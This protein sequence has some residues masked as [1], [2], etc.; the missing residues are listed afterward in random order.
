MANIKI[1]VDSSANLSELAG[2]AFYSAPLKIITSIKEYIDD[3]R[4]DVSQMVSD[5]LENKER[6]STSCPNVGDWLTAF[7]DDEQILCVTI[8]GALSG[9]YNS[10]VLAKQTYETQHPERSVFV[11]DSLSTG[12]EMVLLVEKARDLAIQGMDFSQICS[13][14]TKYSEK[15]VLLFM[16]ESMRNLANNGRV[17]PLAAK[18][19]GILGIRIVGKASDHGTLELLHKCRGEKKA[20]QTMF[21]EMNNAGYGGGK[22]KIA[23]CLNAEAAASLR[24][25]IQE[26]F[27]GTTVEI[28]PCGGLCSYY[29]EKGGLLVAFEKE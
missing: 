11:L 23:H 18:A 25:L 26:A 4:L 24:A 19:A 13:E 29:A 6:T 28:S 20:L 14:V 9:S 2:V 5:L 15:T 10:A 3:I 17:S 7:G 12:P 16:L 27:P 21:S 8:S 1:V 22:V